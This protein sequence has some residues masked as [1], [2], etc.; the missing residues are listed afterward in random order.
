M[1]KSFMPALTLL[2][3]ACL[4]NISFA[5]ISRSPHDVVFWHNTNQLGSRVNTGVCS[6]C[7]IPHS[8][9]GDRLF[10]ISKVV[11]T[12]GVSNKEKVGTVAF[13]CA[14]CH[15][16]IDTDFTAAHLDPSNEII[17]RALYKPDRAADTTA[18][19][20][21]PTLYTSAYLADT[22]GLGI[23]DSTSTTAA[24]IKWP[25]YEDWLKGKRNIECTT[26][27]N[28]H[29]WNQGSRRNYLRAAYFDSSASD[30]GTT[31]DS[32][33]RNICSF[34]HTG[35]DKSGRGTSNEG[36]H[37]VGNIVADPNSFAMNSAYVGIWLDTLNCDPDS[38]GTRFFKK[39]KDT[40]GAS[41]SKAGRAVGDRGAH[42]GPSGE[43]ICMSC[44]MPHGA[45]NSQDGV[46]SA[47][48]T[49]EL[50]VGPLL[51][52]DND[53]SGYS[54]SA[55]DVFQDAYSHWYIETA[56]VIAEGE[57]N[58][59]EWCHG[60]TP[61]K[62][63]TADYATADVDFVKRKYAHPVNNYPAST[64]DNTTRAY[65][66][67]LAN[68]IYSSTDIGLRIRYP[69][70]ADSTSIS[71][72][73]YE[74]SGA[75]N[76]HAM[77]TTRVSGTYY[78]V[79]MSCHDA[80]FG[81]V[82][83]PI[84]RAQSSPQFCEDCH[85]QNPLP[86]GASHPVKGLKPGVICNLETEDGSGASFTLPNYARLPL[87]GTGANAEVIC[88]T[89]HG[90]VFG[91][92][93]IH[94]AMGRF[95]LADYIDFAELC[96]NCHGWWD[97]AAI[98]LSTTYSKGLL[99]TLRV[100]T[101]KQKSANPSYWYLEGPSPAWVHKDSTE[102]YG[103]SRL[104][105]HYIGVISNNRPYLSN[106]TYGWLGSSDTTLDHRG[107]IENTT[108]V[109][110]WL[111]T[112]WF[113]GWP[114]RRKWTYATDG[115][116]VDQ[117]SIVGYLYGTTTMPVITCLSCHTPHGAAA[118]GSAG[119][120]PV[121][122]TTEDSTWSGELLLAKNTGS[123]ICYTCH[124]PAATH[125]V[126]EPDTT[127]PGHKETPGNPKNPDNRHDWVSKTDSTINIYDTVEPKKVVRESAA[128]YKPANYPYGRMV[129]E[130]CHSAHSANS[131]WG[132]YILEGNTT[133]TGNYS[134]AWTSAD[135]GYYNKRPV[136][137]HTQHD[138][139]KTVNDRPTCEMC[140][141]QGE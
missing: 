62:T 14:Q 61:K 42:L 67:N 34:C 99:D 86:A 36:S 82:G 121:D 17:F 28:A 56:F 40:T 37:P 133:N 115:V 3:I 29:E 58:L 106:A 89:C 52:K 9:K 50:V 100:G 30:Y 60:I 71:W 102:L 39:Y 104:G 125:P 94:G 49:F 57:S 129:C 126:D 41:G 75:P 95:L 38:T 119:N 55:V 53:G 81:E 6:F 128:V 124:F 4:Y 22:A 66:S 35:R 2:L 101:A 13:L 85:Y 27:H 112:T 45:P 65:I 12:T 116:G 76:V 122:D 46:T 78:L 139:T 8:A 7:H 107:E 140:H 33:F 69:V 97:T 137:N 93:V 108:D 136:A 138:T 31:Y 92:G 70:H 73:N 118:G 19:D 24:S 54:S 83:T 110:N 120:G 77:G 123:Y 109:D 72:V 103:T 84:L 74:E 64:A 132:S 131:R 16:S 44:H 1:K 5:G 130:S 127:H 11:E 117:Y 63:D 10:P 91:T 68:E 25:Y 18:Y 47:N 20:T 135:T 15:T 111:D 105:S 23:A 59:C 88:R 21:H 114:G 43:F 79:C 32:D 87:L 48:D 26:C 98:P 51:V 134:S 113:G 141:P 80:H 96:V 90:G